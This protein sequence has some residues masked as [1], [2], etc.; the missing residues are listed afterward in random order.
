M[1]YYDAF[2]GIG[3]FH[4][5]MSRLGHECVGAC[6]I[7]KNCR[8]VYFQ[9]HGVKPEGDIK[10]ITEF[11][12][13]DILC[14]GNPCTS[15]SNAGKKG[16]MGDYRGQ[17][18]NE[19]FRV[20]KLKKPKYMFLENVK[21]IKKIDNG[22]IFEYICKEIKDAGYQL[23]T[24]ELSPHQL[25]IPQHRER[26]IFA[27]VRE[28][29]FKGT[30]NLITKCTPRDIFEKNVQGYNISEEQNN[31]LEVWN[32]MIKSFEVNETISPAILINEFYSEKTD[33]FK[34]FKRLYDKYKDDWY[35]WYLVFQEIIQLKKIYGKLEWQ[36]GKI[37]PDDSIFNYFIQFRQSGI[38][39]KKTDYFPTLVAIVQTPIYGKERRYL[40]PRE[41]ARLQS[42]PDDFS[43]HS[44]DKIAYKQL[45]NAVNVDVVFTVISQIILI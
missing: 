1:K 34:K 6:D 19:V 40:T 5:A 36:V 17:L 31:I 2:C 37:K 25:G 23:Q 13:F 39:V 20:A 11:P 35:E 26:V 44:S 22:K 21:H 28:D 18:F 42:F 32:I 33:K 14:S 16:G 41:C 15:F 43:L 7:D 38:R 9:N 30:I 8:E 3:G 29:I 4:I 10:K 24:F 45:G 12:D 27:C